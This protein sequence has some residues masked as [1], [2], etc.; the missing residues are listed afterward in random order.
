[1]HNSPPQI[2]IDIK[3]LLTLIYSYC[4]IIYVHI[5]FFF[6]F[7]CFLFS[8]L[9]MLPV[10]T[11]KIYYTDLTTGMAQ[12]TSL[13]ANTLLLFLIIFFCPSWPRVCHRSVYASNRF[14]LVYHLLCLFCVGNL[15]FSPSWSRLPFVCNPVFFVLQNIH[16]K[17]RCVPF[18]G[19]FVWFS[20]L[21][22]V[23]HLCK[24]FLPNCHRLSDQ[25]LVR[26]GCDLCSDHRKKKNYLTQFVEALSAKSGFCVW[27]TPLINLRFNRSSKAT[28]GLV[29]YS[30]PSF[31]PN[32]IWISYLN[33]AGN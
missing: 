11:T 1:M 10:F 27:F 6:S 25:F 24:S 9:Y 5:I 4:S 30:L 21:R 12:I 22:Q 16:R 26:S 23:L 17:D 18:F 13:S 14:S 3:T 19:E 31:L 32:C 7:C 2:Y 29:M 20:V 28:V 8:E 33:E 15:C